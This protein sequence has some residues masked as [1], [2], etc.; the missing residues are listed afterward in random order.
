MGRLGDRLKQLRATAGWTV[1]DFATRIGKTPG[2]ISRIEARGEM[3]S[4]E[5]LCQIAEMY[6]VPPEEILT[7][8]A[9]EKIAEVAREI[10]EKHAT[11]L[12]LY[13]KEK[14]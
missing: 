8:A 11:A 12:Q 7:L 9:E 2:Y 6:G 13:R 4:P 14:Q 10:E 1:R 5:L 3:P